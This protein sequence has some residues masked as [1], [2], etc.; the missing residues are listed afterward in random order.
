MSTDFNPSHVSILHNPHPDYGYDAPGH[1]VPVGYL[2]FDEIDH[3]LTG[4]APRDTDDRHR[5]AGEAMRELLAWTCQPPRLRSKLIRFCAMAGALRPEFLND[6]T[7]LQIGSELGITK[8]AVSKAVMLFQ[9]HFKFKAARSR[10]ESAR[11][12]MAAARIGGPDRH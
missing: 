6:R 9:D 8:S 2:D 10:P 1:R 7:Y 11:K 12:R 3:R 5:D 4:E